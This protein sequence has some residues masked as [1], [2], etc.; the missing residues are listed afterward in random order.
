MFRQLSLSLVI[1]ALATTFTTHIATA[2]IDVQ[3]QNMVALYRFDEGSGT[4]AVDSAVLEGIQTANQN[5]G[6]IGWTTGLVGGAL[7]LDGSSS[8]QAPD[9]IGEGAEAFTISVWVNLDGNPG[10]DGI[11]AARDTENWGLNVEGGSA[12]NLH[13]DF[14]YDNPPVGSGG[15]QGVDSANGTAIADDAA[16]GNNGWQHL[17]MTWTAVTPTNGGFRDI[18]L[19]GVDVGGANDTVASEYSGYLSTWNIGDDPCCGGRE[20]DAQLDELAVWNVAL[21]ASEIMTIYN[22]GISGT[23]QGLMA[24]VDP[25]VP[26]DVN[27]DTLVNSVDFDKIRQNF[28]TAQ[29][30]RTEGD[31]VNDDFVDFSDYAQWKQVSPKDPDPAGAFAS[32]ASVP[33]PSA[34]LMVIFSA[35]G[36]GW[37][38]KRQ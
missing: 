13:F 21:S 25:N 15:S 33:E 32:G 36:L 10:Y 9:A 11:Y 29:T 17:A 38:T 18:Y 24:P 26:G 6:T 8:L 35:A 2:Q 12:A 20:L 14:R 28:F 3:S 19:N 1:A 34:L 16:A 30:E 31:L 7:D 4:S 27:G 22:D 5:Q 37:L 23:P